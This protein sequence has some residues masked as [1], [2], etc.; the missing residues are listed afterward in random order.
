MNKELTY[1]QE[2]YLEVEAKE[3][4]YNKKYRK[5]QQ[6]ANNINAF[7]ILYCESCKLHFK[8]KKDYGN[9]VTCPYCGDYMDG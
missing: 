9:I 1:A 2:N 6:L 5:K 7:T 3:R 4:Y 8:V